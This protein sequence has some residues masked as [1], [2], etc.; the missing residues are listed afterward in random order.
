MSQ[1]PGIRYS[2]VASI[3][4]A[5]GGGRNV[6]AAETER[7]PSPLTTTARSACTEEVPGLITV[8]W[9]ITI[10]PLGS[11]A[12]SSV[13]PAKA[14]DTQATIVA[15]KQERRRRMGEGYYGK[16][17]RESREAGPAR[18]DCHGIPRPH[19]FAGWHDTVCP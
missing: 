18:F 16:A 5:P 10:G 3:T 2:P 14:R 19:A 13:A 6:A 12:A 17:Q 15:T 11:C 4:R 7:I 9:V 8:A 1:R